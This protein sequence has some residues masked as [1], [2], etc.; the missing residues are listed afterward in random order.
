[1]KI[2]FDEVSRQSTR[3]GECSVCHKKRTVTRKFFQ[4]INPFNKNAEGEVK[5]RS[6]IE[7]ELSAQSVAWHN[8][9]LVCKGCEG[10]SR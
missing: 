1:M 2:T 8:E 7:K 3:K 6:E 5:G 4:T 9:P 10:T